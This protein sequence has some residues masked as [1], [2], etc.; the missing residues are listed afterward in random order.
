MSLKSAPRFDAIVSADAFEN[1]K[2]APDI[3]LAASK[4]LDVPTN[5]VC[6]QR[7]FKLIISCICLGI[8]SNGGKIIIRW[9]FVVRGLKH[10]LDA[11]LSSY[12]TFFWGRK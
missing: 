6:F 1:L 11:Q 5:E 7:L 4:I 9:G 12:L 3:F 2:P 10:Y 8:G